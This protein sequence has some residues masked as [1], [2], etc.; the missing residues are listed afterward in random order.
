[1]NVQECLTSLVHKARKRHQGDESLLIWL[2]GGFASQNK[3]CQPHVA[4]SRISRRSQ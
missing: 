2:R 1:M 3:G 4:V